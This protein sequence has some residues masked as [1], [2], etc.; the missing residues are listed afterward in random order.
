MHSLCSHLSGA[1]N[2]ADHLCRQDGLP[3]YDIA[4]CKH[5]RCWHS[6]SSITRDRSGWAIRAVTTSF[7]P[8][9]L[10]GPA[11][12]VREPAARQVLQSIQQ[13]ALRVPGLSRPVNTTYVGPGAYSPTA[14][15]L[16][17]AQVP[18]TQC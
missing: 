4:A 5:T 16:S 8:A 7:E 13:V 9:W 15:G 2:K 1:L 17:Q 10:A 6:N 11:Q 12:E 14:E 3:G 18:L